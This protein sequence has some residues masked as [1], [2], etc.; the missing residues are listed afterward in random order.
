MLKLELTNKFK[1][2]FEKLKKQGKDLKKLKSVLLILQS[3]DILPL[4]N[5][6]HQLK[7]KLK[8]F[9]ECHIEPD[10]L[11]MYKVEKDILIL[12]RTGSHAELFE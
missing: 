4:K 2:D 9:R 11:L 7:G 12:A 1:K 5:K 10:W 8:E 3:K 6:D